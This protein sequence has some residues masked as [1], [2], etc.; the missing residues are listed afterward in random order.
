MIWDDIDR[1]LNATPLL[2]LGLIVLA[3]MVSAVL[4]GVALRRFTDR[5]DAMRGAPAAEGLEGIMVSAILAL[6]ALLMAFTYS[7]VLGRFEDRRALVL[8]EANAIGTVYLRA[9]LLEPPHRERISRLLVDYTGVRVA[10]AQST[11]TRNADLIAQNDR[12][13]TALW[14]ATMAA[15]PSIK[16]PGLSAQFLQ[17]MNGLLDL[18]TSRKMAR[19][20]HVPAEVFLVVFVFLVATTAS[21][22]TCWSVA[23]AG[24][25]S[26]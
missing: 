19:V 7:I 9:Q 11:R 13:V 23:G 14:A 2:A 24:L 20:V 4:V 10:L 12:L 22:A 16:E 15:Y 21:S 1:W 6:M 8:E 25:S 26:A 3:A 17:S 18:D 5:R